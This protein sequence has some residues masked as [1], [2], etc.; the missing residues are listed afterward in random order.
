VTDGGVDAAERYIDIGPRAATLE[1]IGTVTVSVDA[2]DGN[3][4]DSLKG[5]KT[6]LAAAVGPELVD[7]SDTLQSTFS[8]SSSA[9]AGSILRASQS[10]TG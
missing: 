1:T 10:R 7:A 2:P 6:G 9:A 3:V 4:T 8:G 5:A